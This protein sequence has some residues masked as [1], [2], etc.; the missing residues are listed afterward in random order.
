MVN[1]EQLAG[2][3]TDWKKINNNEQCANE[4]T[5]RKIWTWKPA[6]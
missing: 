1:R 6:N 5:T 3:L 4:T 2:W